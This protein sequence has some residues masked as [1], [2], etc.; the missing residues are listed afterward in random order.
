MSLMRP[1]ILHVAVVV[2]RRRGRRCASSASASIASRGALRVV[3]VAEHHGVAA[4]A[5]LARLAAADRGAG[6]G[7]DDLDL[8][9]RDA[10]ARPCRRAGRSG[11]RAP[12][13]STR[14]TSRSCRRRSSP[15]PCACRT[16]QRFITS[17]GHGAPAMIPVR[18]DDRSNVGEVVELELGDEHRRHAVQAR[19]PFGRD[20]LERRAR[21]EAGRGHHHRGAVRRAREVAEHHA[22]AVVERHR[23]ADA[24][25]LGV[26]ATFADEVAVVQDV[27]VA[28]RR[29]LREA[30]RAARVLDVDRIV[31]RE[32]GRAPVDGAGVDRRP[33]PR[34]TASQS[35]CPRKTTRSSC[36]EVRRA[37]R[38]P[39]RGSRSS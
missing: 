16:T 18:S 5:E 15:L 14:A 9:V 36:G 4:R 12:S 38:R 28:E 22:E 35:R 31:E 26:A 33:A 30:R 34:R 37:P 17:T 2:H 24:V 20:R 8:D 25:G 3:P 29:A 13:A 11:R 23:D 21:L 39:S 19:A 1:T 32:L 27:V 6:A 7:I 10:R